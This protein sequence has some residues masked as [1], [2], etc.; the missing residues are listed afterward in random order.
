MTKNIP[1][2]LL[3]SLFVLSL[4]STSAMANC[5]DDIKKVEKRKEDMN[6]R[7]EGGIQSV[8]RMI[9]KAKKA[10][11]DGKMEKCAHIV[12]KAN[13]KIDSDH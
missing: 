8:E 13:A 10:L 9:E 2:A 1:G 11:A 6:Y 5:A 4:A 3:A 12:E 7:N